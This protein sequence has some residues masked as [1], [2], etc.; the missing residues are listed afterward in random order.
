MSLNNCVACGCNGKLK[1]SEKID[2]NLIN[3]FTFASRKRPELMHYAL[4]ECDNCFTL[5][6]NRDV[7]IK[8]LLNKYEKASF[9][10]NQEA[11][12]AAKT[13]VKLI[14]KALPNFKGTVLDVGTGD[15]AFLTE[16]LNKIANIAV[17][18]EPSV[19]AIRFN[20]N[21]EI[22]IVQTSFEEFNT[23]MKYDLITCF[24]TIE[25]L[26]NPKVFLNKFIEFLNPGGYIVISC[27]TN[28]S[29]INKI[30]GE[31][32]PIF[33]IEHLQVFSKKGIKFLF[34]EVG[35][36]IIYAN[37]YWNSYPISYWIKIS[38][39]GDK[40]KDFFQK[41][42]DFLRLNLKVNVGNYLIIG[43]KKD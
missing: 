39:I 9:D 28:N 21:P 14:Q 11:K 15:G 40:I 13:Y 37:S 31:K 12:F 26:N 36:D 1:Y 5:F 10:S 34:Q 22:E 33:D 2:S 24:Q 23:D 18:I 3:E 17:G 42:K 19:A 6:T 29:I 7:N 32:S 30:L 43:R 4:F 25:H 41:N 38:P 20:K 27:H 8:D 35:L 16:A